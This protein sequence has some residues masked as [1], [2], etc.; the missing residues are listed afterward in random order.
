MKLFSIF[1]GSPLPSFIT[2][3]HQDLIFGVDSSPSKKKAEFQEQEDLSKEGNIKYDSNGEA[4]D[5]I[6]DIIPN[7]DVYIA[8]GQFIRVNDKLENAPQSK[9]AV[10]ILCKE[11]ILN[12]KIPNELKQLKHSKEATEEVLQESLKDDFGEGAEFNNG[13]SLRR[14]RNPTVTAQPVGSMRGSGNLRINASLINGFNIN[15]Q[16]NKPIISWRIPFVNIHS[17]VPS[18]LFS[19]MFKIWYSDEKRTNRKVVGKYLFSKTYECE[20]E[21]ERNEWVMIINRVIQDYYQ[22]LLEKHIIPEPEVYQFHVWVQRLE[23][24]HKDALKCVAFSTEKVYILNMNI[25]D[26]NPKNM[27]PFYS[28]PIESIILKRSSKATEVFCIE[29]DKEILVQCKVKEKSQRYD[30]KCIDEISLSNLFKEINRLYYMRTKRLPL[31]NQLE[32]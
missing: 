21:Q 19:N 3:K 25:G 10:I 2:N 27:K 11:S 15:W 14:R 23:K 6:L 30:F 7:G 17:V 4:L 12:I 8:S 9:E 31:V 13:F 28:Y 26:D 24:K 29:F 18:E 5:P 20:N 32:D 16:K 1:K 22:A